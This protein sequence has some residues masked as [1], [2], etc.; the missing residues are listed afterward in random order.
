LPSALLSYKEEEK[1]TVNLIR[2]STI[3]A[4]LTPLF[5]LAVPAMA[6]QQYRIPVGINAS[7]D[8]QIGQSLVYTLKE[9]LLRSAVFSY[10][11]DQ[12]GFVLNIVTVASSS[13]VQGAAAVVLTVKDKEGNQY[14]LD[15]WVAGMTNTDDKITSMARHLLASLSED[16][17]RF[18]KALAQQPRVDPS[19]KVY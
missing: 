3:I 12:T 8:D 2:K 6:Q 13:N 10:T 5:T 15:Q 19:V 11:T 17:D 4:I 7:T 18:Q 14:Y 9:Q 16:M 1:S